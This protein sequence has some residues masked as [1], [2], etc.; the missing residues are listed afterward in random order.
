MHESEINQR[1]I[2]ETFGSI[3][4]ILQKIIIIKSSNKHFDFKSRI[5]WMSI[6]CMNHNFFEMVKSL[7]NTRKPSTTSIYRWFNKEIKF[8]FNDYQKNRKH[9]SNIQI[10]YRKTKY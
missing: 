4:T 5:F 7:L 9:N 2:E 8:R 1:K 3:Q 6:F 10:L